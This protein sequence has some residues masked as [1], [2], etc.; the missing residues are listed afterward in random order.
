MSSIVLKQIN[1]KYKIPK[2]IKLKIKRNN[3]KYEYNGKIYEEIRKDNKEV[4]QVSLLVNALN[5]KDKKKRIEYV[6]DK[7]CE[8]LDD[9]FYGKNLCEFKNNKCIHD[10]LLCGTT[11][12]CC[13]ANDGL[14][15]CKYLINHKCSVSCLAC[16]FH[17]CRCLRKK[18]YKYRVSDIYLLK[19]LY[20]FK[21]K[22]IIYN[23]FFMSK[24][25]VL[26]D[27]NRN[28]LLYW[29]FFNKSRSFIKD[30]KKDL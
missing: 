30:N 24:E 28:S 7:S 12:G 18:G 4:Y 10:R 1:G 29:V 20:N 5:I 14:S 2:F 21:Q 23:D 27:V 22:V 13:R 9:D 11:D 15:K 8:L 25:E 16:K 3:F 6:Y 17:I 19:Y 26:K